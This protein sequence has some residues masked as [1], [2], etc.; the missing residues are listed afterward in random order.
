M[1]DLPIKRALLSVSDKTG[2]IERA[3]KL[4]DLGVELL[5][6]AF[7]VLFLD[8]VVVDGLLNFV[9]YLLVCIELV[10]SLRLFDIELPA[11]SLHL[12]LELFGN[13][14]PLFVL[15][16]EHDLMEVLIIAPLLKVVNNGHLG[17]IIL[18]C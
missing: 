5:H 9:S 3:K 13:F 16:V 18:D 12:L 4:A 10:L 8:L 14:G 1:T 15:L 17:R 2:L 6:L 7:V 11:Q